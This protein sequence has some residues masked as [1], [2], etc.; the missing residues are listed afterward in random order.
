MNVPHRVLIADDDPT[1]RDALRA[2][3]APEG[4]DLVL[5]G[6]G[7]QALARAAELTPDLMLLDVMM[8][9]MDGFEVCRRLRDD[10]LLSDVPVLMITALDDHRSR[11]QGIEAGADDFISKPFDDTELQARV[12]TIL[13]LNRYRRLLAERTQREQAEEALAQRVTQLALLN[14]IG[15][16]IASMLELDSLLSETVRLVQDFGYAQVALFTLDG[17]DGDLVLRASAGASDRQLHPGHRVPAGQG[18]TG[19]VAEQGTVLLV[20]N[21]T[22]GP[23]PGYPPSNDQQFQAQLSVPLRLGGEV[24]GVLDVRSPLPKTFNEGDVMVME[25]LA[26]AVATAMHNA[27]LYEAERAS[28]KRLRDLAGYLETA[29]ERERTYIAREIHDEFGQALTALKMDVVWLAKHLP[30]DET[31]L[32]EKAQVMSQLVDSTISMVRRIATDLRPGILDHLGLVAAIEWQ[33]QEVAGR[34]GFECQL[35]LNDLEPELDPDL[36]TAIFRIFQ[37]TLTNVARHAGANLVR[38]KLRTK[39]DQLILVVQ[40]N[41]RGITQRQ[42][43]DPK[44]L[45]LIGMQERA[46]LLGG[47]VEFQAAPGGGTKVTVRVPKTGG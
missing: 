20:N 44:S 14:K 34:A 13:R 31:K 9:G 1:M 19:W 35:L 43:L 33:A 23:H 7:P 10:T 26:D 39:D 45:G 32:L 3:L 16:R 47:E 38:V 27:Q 5:A 37:E 40:D 46:R 15:S 2:V 4:Y 36:A 18:R 8:P 12:R 30:P 22:A 42:M 17:E 29:R 41:G 24:V 25:T 11:L 6:S 28:R 21:P